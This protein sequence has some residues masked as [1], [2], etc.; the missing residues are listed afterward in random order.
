MQIAALA[1]Q[2]MTNPEIADQLFLSPR[3]I[4]YHLHKVF[5]KLGLTSRTQLVRYGLPQPA[6]PPQ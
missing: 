1:A 5:T 4:D 3:T 2:G 6:E